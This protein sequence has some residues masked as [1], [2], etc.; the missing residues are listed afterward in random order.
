MAKNIFNVWNEYTNA[1][2]AND[3]R[4][5][6]Y[7][8][9]YDEWLQ[10]REIICETRPETEKIKTLEEKINEV[11][12][13]KNQIKNLIE[14]E[15]S[16]LTKKQIK[17]NETTPTIEELQ[18]KLETCESFI[19]TYK[20]RLQDEIDAE[21]QNL[22]SQHDRARPRMLV[23]QKEKAIL[24]RLK[25]AYKSLNLDTLGVCNLLKSNTGKE[26]RVKYELVPALGIK[27]KYCVSINVYEYNSE[28]KIKAEVSHGTYKMRKI[29]SHLVN[30]RLVV[31]TDDSSWMEKFLNDLYKLED[32]IFVNF[33]TLQNDSS[34]MFR[35]IMKAME[36]PYYEI[37]KQELT[38]VKEKEVVE[39]VEEDV[40]LLEENL[41]ISK[42]I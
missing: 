23:I 40:K 41:N 34:E 37:L 6:D 21:I 4:R 15:K 11:I 36:K 9:R 32:V 22:L 39:E 13:Y 5:V 7:S 19:A 12:K 20:V 29:Y 27:D 28:D 42:N 24:E 31:G 35:Y 3:K 16:K 1:A 2:L 14:A 30:D 25:K 17:R 38:E 26:Y 18:K 8:V 33:E 10:K